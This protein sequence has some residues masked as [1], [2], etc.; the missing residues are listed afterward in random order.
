MPRHRSDIDEEVLW[1]GVGSISGL[2][3]SNDTPSCRNPI[4]FKP[5][6]QSRPAIHHE[7]QR[8]SDQ[9]APPAAPKKESFFHHLGAAIASQLPHLAEYLGAAAAVGIKV[10]PQAATAAAVIQAIAAAHKEPPPAEAP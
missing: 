6:G 2:T 9:N 4:G 7:R 5:S 1:Q 3:E 10:S 8:M